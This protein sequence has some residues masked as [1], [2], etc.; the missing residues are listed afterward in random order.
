LSTAVTSVADHLMGA[1]ERG[2]SALLIAKPATIAEVGEELDGRG[3]AI[4]ALVREGRLVLLDA[5]ASLAAMRVDTS[6][7]PYRFSATLESTLR[8]TVQRAKGKPVH[9]FSELGSLVSTAIARSRIEEL[10]RTACQELGVVAAQDDTAP[11]APQGRMQKLL[12]LGNDLAAALTRDEVVARTLAQGL[13]CIDAVALSVWGVV[14]G[15]LE[16]LGVSASYNRMA[17]PPVPT[18]VSGHTPLAAAVRTGEGVFLRCAE[19]YRASFPA[20]YERMRAHAVFDEIAIAAL[21]FVGSS[22]RIL[23]GIVFMYDGHREL[24]GAERAFL[25]I[26][27][28]QV[29]LALERLDAYEHERRARYETELLNRLA[30]QVLRPAREL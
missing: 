26:L 30:V 5:E 10:W 20:S 14:G 17:P 21:P 3:V 7:D 27:A 25:A 22:G 4:D 19:V 24:S 16:P 15:K 2:G 11:L 18:A 1:L 13:R 12:E 23:G 9:A 8:C 6:I 29:A 28:R